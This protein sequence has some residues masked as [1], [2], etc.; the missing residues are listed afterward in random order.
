[1]F[2]CARLRDEQDIDMI[3]LG[4]NNACI[5]TK[6]DRLIE[7]GSVNAELIA[8]GMR[9]GNRLVMNVAYPRRIGE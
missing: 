6:E 7:R 9:T 4:I 2:G 3:K 1:M 8:A 5:L